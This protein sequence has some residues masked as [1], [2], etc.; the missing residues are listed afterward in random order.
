MAG[1]MNGVWL[2]E[3]RAELLGGQ[4]KTHRVRREMGSHWGRTWKPGCLGSQQQEGLG[5]C[6][7]VLVTPRLFSSPDPLGS[8]SVSGE[9]GADWLE[10]GS[11]LGASDSRE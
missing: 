10:E 9:R 4:W 6:E 3:A 1:S 11:A 5:S 8:L 2:P 7:R